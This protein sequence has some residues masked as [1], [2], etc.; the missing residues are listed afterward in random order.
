ME[1]R[2]WFNCYK[3]DKKAGKG[4][5][6]RQILQSI[7]EELNKPRETHWWNRNR[8]CLPAYIPQRINEYFKGWRHHK[9]DGRY[10]T[11]AHYDRIFVGYDPETKEKIYVNGDW[12]DPELKYKSEG[13]YLTDSYGRVIPS[14]F[15]KACYLRFKPAPIVVKKVSRWYRRYGSFVF[16][17]GPV[18]GISKYRNGHWHKYGGNHGGFV[19]WKRSWYAF[20]V[21]RKEIYEEYGIMLKT[22]KIIPFTYSKGEGKGWKRTRKKKQWM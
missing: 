6:W 3:G 21:D 7:H 20:D 13:T 15:V 17:R 8:E 16:R 18:E 2:Y 11:A 22:Q 5:T 9:N 10:W 12:H 1:E 19:H 4:K 14:G